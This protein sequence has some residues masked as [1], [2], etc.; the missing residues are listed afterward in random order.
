MTLSVLEDEE[1]DAEASASP[2]C[3]ST[4]DNADWPEL[5]ERI[6]RG[7]ESG[8]EDL[9]RIFAKGVGYP[10]ARQIGRRETQDRVHDTFLIVVNA[11]Q[12]GELRD[13]CRLAGFVK[14]VVKRQ[15]AAHIDTA[16]KKRREERDSYIKTC[17]ADRRI[18]AEQRFAFGQKVEL[19]RSVLNELSKR[20][21]DILVRSYLNEQSPGRICQEMNLTETQFRL[22]KSRAKAQF[23][24]L[25][26]QRLHR[27]ELL[28]TMVRSAAMSRSN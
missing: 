10:F 23:G 19:M 11:I 25:G 18:T 21:R 15:I 8:M 17:V 7:E 24:N 6:R 2:V 22:L 14:T 20:N 5:V 9:Y 4:T 27:G 13:P 16:C 28:A 1:P 12:S 3:C 26:K